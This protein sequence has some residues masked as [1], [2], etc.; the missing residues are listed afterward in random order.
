MSY[1]LFVYLAAVKIQKSTVQSDIEVGSECVEP[2]VLTLPKDLPVPEFSYSSSDDDDFYD[3]ADD[4]SSPS[5]SQNHT[6]MQV[7]FIS[8]FFKQ[9]Y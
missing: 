7:I 4:I 6:L 1:I 2:R 9:F 5:V 8:L 3:A